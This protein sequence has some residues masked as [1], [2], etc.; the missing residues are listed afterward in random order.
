M[1]ESSPRIAK[2]GGR[3]PRRCAMKTHGPGSVQRPRHLTTSPAGRA[4]IALLLL[5]SFGGAA[6]GHDRV[7][8]PPY[9]RATLAEIAD[10]V[11]HRAS[12]APEQWG[13]APHRAPAREASA[14]EGP[15]DPEPPVSHMA[16]AREGIAVSIP[17]GARTR[18][19][20]APAPAVGYESNSWRQ[21]PV[22]TRGLSFSSGV[23]APASGLDPALRAHGGALRAD[24][25]ES[26][27]GFVL[28]RVPP[29]DALERTL[30][31]L[32]VTL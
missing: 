8:A 32:G 14:D 12:P 20:I 6:S 17:P 31:G 27:Y 13:T 1:C 26:V 19:S 15:E 9:D 28:L 2:G 21:R 30:A 16:P 23:R 4:G 29:D 7:S 11:L 18:G 22:A 10:G 5:A 25:R 24:G 3:R